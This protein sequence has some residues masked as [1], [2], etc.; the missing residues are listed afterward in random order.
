MTQRGRGI[1]GDRAKLGESAT[2]R[3]S[4]KVG[5]ESEAGREGER[6]RQQRQGRERRVRGEGMDVKSHSFVFRTE[7]NIY[8]PKSKS[9]LTIPEHTIT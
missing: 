7:R 8:Y 6:G 1:G 3:G 2:Q 5:R 9:P 4:G